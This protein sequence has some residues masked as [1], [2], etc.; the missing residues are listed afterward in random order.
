MS[1]NQYPCPECGAVLRPKNPIGA[2]KKVKCPKCETVFAPVPAAEEARAKPAKAAVKKTDD[3]D[4]GGYGIKEDAADTEETKAQRKKALGP[5]SDKDRKPRSARGPAAAICTQPSNKM[6]GSAL[7]TA[8]GSVITIVVVLWPLVF[9]LE[10]KEDPDAPAPT[11]PKVVVSP[12]EKAEQKKQRAIIGAIVITGA[13]FTLIYNVLIAMGASKMQGVESYA[14]AMAA[15]ILLIIPVNWGLVYFG[16][17]WFIKMVVAIAG[18]EYA[19]MFLMLTV[20]AIII[21]DTYIGVLNIITLR[22]PEVIAGFQEKKPV[23]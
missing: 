9:A 17:F 11:K 1:D 2:G 20:G 3:D 10:R 21:W 15:A 22:K 19:E 13:V 4:E 16:F 6:L 14:W 8:I 18:Q 5:V 7:I 12:E 23:V